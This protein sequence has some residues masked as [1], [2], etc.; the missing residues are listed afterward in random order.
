M[1]MKNKANML[2]FFSGISPNPD[3]KRNL[4]FVVRIGITGYFFFQQLPGRTS[5]GEVICEFVE[6]VMGEN[7]MFL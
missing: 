1:E 6:N 2:D 7:S 5:G 4:D 3:P